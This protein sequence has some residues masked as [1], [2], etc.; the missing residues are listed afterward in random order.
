[1]KTG[2]FLTDKEMDFMINLIENEID[3]NKSFVNDLK[4]RQEVN[5]WNKETE[6][7]KTLLETIKL[8][9]V[10]EHKEVKN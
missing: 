10:V 6:E 1:M 4:D 3:S 7:L 8:K 9:G 5:F 2:I